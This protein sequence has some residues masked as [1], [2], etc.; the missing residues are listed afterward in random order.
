V[1]ITYSATF[2]CLR[3][4]DQFIVLEQQVESSRVDVNFVQDIWLK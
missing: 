2:V 3:V 4:C 1:H